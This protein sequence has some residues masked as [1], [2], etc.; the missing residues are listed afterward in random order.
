M[1]SLVAERHKEALISSTEVR[2]RTKIIAARK[3]AF[4]QRGL[5]VFIQQMRAI[6]SLLGHAQAW[7]KTTQRLGT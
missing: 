6:Y 1:I 3:Y 2:I 7:L 4:D 5:C